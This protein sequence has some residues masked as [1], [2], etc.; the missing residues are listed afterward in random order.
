MAEEST[1]KKGQLAAAV[2]AG[3]ALAFSS[4]AV[5]VPAA[6]ADEEPS[7]AIA[8]ATP[9]P[10]ETI[11]ATPEAPSPSEDPTTT[12]ETEDTEGD[13]LGE[14]ADS[15][16][17][18]TDAPASS[19]PA[20]A[21][22]AAPSAPQRTAAED[23]DSDSEI[24][25]FQAQQQEL[26]FTI[27]PTYGPAGT[28]IDF[29]G[30]G[31]TPGEPVDIAVTDDDEGGEGVNY[32]RVNADEDGN[33]SGS[34]S[35]T[36]GYLRGLYTV[37]A[38]GEESGRS[39]QDTFH[40]TNADLSVNPAS[41]SA[42]EFASS[43]VTATVE[44]LQAGEQVT[45]E[46][47]HRGSVAGDL[48]GTATANDEGVAVLTIQS[49]E[50]GYVGT[51]SVR[52]SDSLGVV[53]SEE[54]EVTSSAPHVIVSSP[55]SD[56]DGVVRPG[57]RLRVSG[58]NA[59]PEHWVHI[60]FGIE[61]LEATED[62]TAEGE[63]SS[64]ITIPEDA[65]PGVYTVTVT[66]NATGAE[67]TAEYTVVA[68][69]DE[70]IE[71][72]LSADRTQIELDDFI[73]S[74]DSGAGV[75]FVVEGLDPNTDFTY[76]AT[77]SGPVADLEATETT[78]E[79]GAARFSVYGDDQASDPSVYLGRYTVTV[80]YED[81]AGD[82]HELGPV[83]FRV[84]ENITEDIEIELEDN[85]VYQGESLDVEIWNLTPEGEVEIEW[86]PTETMTA[87]DDGEI[88]VDLPIAEDA[89]TGVQ[90]LTVTDLTT[91][92]TASVEYTVLE[93]DEGSEEPSDEVFD[94]SLAI[95]PERID[96]DDFIGEPEDGAGVS[97]MVRG[98]NPDTD[99]IS[100]AITG[101]EYVNDFESSAD[102]EDDGVA[103]FV[104]HGY[105]VANPSV[106]VGEYTTVVTYVDEEGDTQTLTGNFT[107]VDGDDD[108]TGGTGGSD[109]GDDDR[110]S[111]GPVDLNGTSGLAQTGANGIQLGMLAGGLLLA[112]GALL[113]FAN[114]KR[115]FGRTA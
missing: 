61:G 98:L 75:G 94:P 82:T 63:Y 83:H 85:E 104:I 50:A 95:D 100:Y 29:S 12:K 38:T 46:V 7:P 87:D 35:I 115:L 77:T 25:T 93:A 113:A 20:P 101:P 109:D 24:E 92:Q 72:T 105:D 73:G 81:E 112:G 57:E 89:A 17:P 99:E 5:G 102:V 40:V 69:E 80:S 52:A 42:E 2:L 68:A 65:E 1:K 76:T 79:E 22:S 70:D 37:T 59:T 88:D 114:R 16:E 10:E 58:Y 97:H 64:E 96:L 74:E 32:T 62:I 78:N 31:F 45:F 55:D 84:V 111:S 23:D 108:S 47:V 49:D 51:F 41:V 106:Y 33:I 67:N 19:E 30:S 34:T 54:F 9:E 18:T 53:D 26:S 39:A 86:N 11:E 15:N 14:E 90:T 3:S 36:D 27:N 8:T 71:P 4:F 66:N 60:D 43:G 44:G 103:S 13:G 6:L 21:D 107:V 28:V 48:G 56:E 110:G 91:E